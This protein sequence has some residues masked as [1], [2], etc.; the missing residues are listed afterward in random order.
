MSSTVSLEDD[1]AQTAH[2]DVAR[3]L[4]P[5]Q[6]QIETA[7]VAW[8]ERARR[9]SIAPLIATLRDAVAAHERIVSELDD[10]APEGIPAY[11]DVLR[12]EVVEPYFNHLTEAR[13]GG[14][15]LEAHAWLLDALSSMATDL[16]EVVERPEPEGLYEPQVSDGWVRRVRKLRVRIGRQLQYSTFAVMNLLR[17]VAGRQPHEPYGDV[18][19]VPMARLGAFHVRV[20]LPAELQTDHEAVCKAVGRAIAAGGRALTEHV[21]AVLEAESKMYDAIA[22]QDGQCG[23][24]AVS[25]VLA[26]AERFHLQLSEAADKLEAFD[27]LG[28]M[29]DKTGELTARLH[30]D[31]HEAGSFMMDERDVERS[32]AVRRRVQDR[33][34]Q[35]AAWYGRGHARIRMLMHLLEF[36]ERTLDL[37]GKLIDDVL[38]AGPYPARDGLSRAERQLVI[39]S[40]RAEK[41]FAKRV[42]ADDVDGRLQEAIEVVERD[43]LSVLQDGRLVDGARHACDDVAVALASA[44]QELP[45]HI[46]INALED[47][48]EPDRQSRRVNLREHAARA[49]DALAIER[50]RRTTGLVADAISTARVEAES[51]PG[52]LRFNLGTAVDDLREKSDVQEA[53]RELVVDGLSRSADVLGSGAATVDGVVEPIRR[54][55]RAVFED[56]F[57]SL[58]QRVRVEERV[59]EQMLDLRTGAEAGARRAV[60]QATERAHRAAVVV[61][62]AYRAGRQRARQWV[63]LGQAAAGLAA[64]TEEERLETVEAL[65]ETDRLLDGFPLVYR[66]LFTFDPVR[67]PSL[68]EGRAQELRVVRRHVG[69]WQSGLTDALVLT[70][71]HGSGQTSFL[72]VVRQTLFEDADVRVLDLRHR[73]RTEAEL[74]EAL[75]DVLRIEAELTRTLD[76]LADCLFARERSSPMPVCMIEHLEHLYLR[77]V[78][79]SKLLEAL[80]LFVSRTDSH[81]LWIATVSDYGWQLIRKAEPAASSLV[82]VHR[83]APITRLGLESIIMTRHRRSGLPLHFELPAADANPLFARRYR[84]A[85]TEP[86]RQEILRTEYFDRLHRASGQNVMLALFYWLRSVNMD[87]E[88]GVLRVT[89]VEPLRFGFLQAFDL[90]QA[91]SLKALLEHASLTVE[92]HSEAFQVPVTRSI[93]IFEAF[94]NLLLIEPMGDGPGRTRFSFATVEEGVRYRIRPLLIH[95][96]IQYLRGKNILH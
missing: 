15:L 19:H 55:V 58:H 53:A 86:E 61:R 24:K 57:S 65:A 70:G 66:R 25:A 43:A 7:A 72:N 96:I 11:R 64:V 73:M 8:T 14:T 31:A 5:L 10:D 60:A 85:R 90:E 49:Y 45:E 52:V 84:R 83:L 39:L 95:P 35:W 30:R 59:R 47:D 80:F 44:V 93:Q 37:A 54:E 56:G 2:D 9:E 18:Q 81:V 32:A 29:G 87:Q 91:F 22:D 12:S 62:K 20:R 4:I 67:D 51:V 16:P 63:Q 33:D 78:G 74:V 38:E 94:G 79:G 69:R 48:V 77:Q 68:L 92:E 76:A 28:M 82:V 42:S 71:F 88:E 17:R 46:E 23:D 27:G 1:S 26:L 6:K 3:L 75:A 13:A 34:A 41:A 40:Q 89:A 50:L 36:R 21:H